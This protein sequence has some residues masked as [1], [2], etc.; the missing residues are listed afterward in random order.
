MDSEIGRGDG[1][2]Q[3]QDHESGGISRVADLALRL[4]SGRGC[5]ASCTVKQLR[6]YAT[7]R[8]TT[9]FFLFNL[10]VSRL[11]RH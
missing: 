11:A 7:N 9:N 10:W 1:W 6:F 8:I 4:A 3:G 2:E 5:I